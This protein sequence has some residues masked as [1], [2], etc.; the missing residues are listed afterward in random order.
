MEYFQYIMMH[1]HVYIG[2]FL[3]HVKEAEVYF[4]CCIY[5]TCLIFPRGCVATSTSTLFV[6]VCERERY[7]NEFFKTGVLI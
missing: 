6:C 5:T 3:L 2:T 7:K 1:V 4:M